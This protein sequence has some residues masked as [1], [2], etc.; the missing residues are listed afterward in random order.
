MQDFEKL[1]AFYLGKAFNPLT[2]TANENLLL[3]DAKDLTTH[4]LMVGMTGSGKTR[5]AVALLEEAPRRHSCHS[6]R[7]GMLEPA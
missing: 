4:V 3:Y 1:D 7:P 6:D 2:A 5:L